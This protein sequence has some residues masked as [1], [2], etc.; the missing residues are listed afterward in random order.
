MF[1]YRIGRTKYAEDLTGEGAR[2]NGGRWNHKLIP[3]IYTS[4]S[5]AL[6]MLE[7]TVNINIEDIPRRLSI[8]T[9][10]IPDKSIYKVPASQLPG[11]WMTSPIPSS[12]KDF[13]TAFLQKT[14]HLILQFPSAVIPAER[15]FIINPLHKNFSKISIV[16]VE[17]FV[18]DIRVKG[19]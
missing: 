1:V 5:R 11:D 14:A 6:A 17:D 12:S 9:F 15:N 2:L 10:E 8:S 18:Y 16:S 4:E 19:A 13:G 3:C 7:Y